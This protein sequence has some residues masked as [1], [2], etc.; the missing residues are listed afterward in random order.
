MLLL[1]TQAEPQ[2]LAFEH[3]NLGHL[4]QPR[5]FPKVVDTAARGVPWAADNDAFVRFDAEAFERMLHALASLPGCLCV[6]CPDVV[7]EGGFTDIL[8]EEWA[9]RIMRHWLPLAYAVQE[10]GLEYE[11]GG[12]PWGAIEALFIGCAGDEEKLGERVRGLVAEAKRRGKWVH[13][14]RVNSARRIAYAKEI[15][16][17]SVDGTKWV[18][19]RDTYLVEGLQ[20]VSAPPQLALANPSPLPGVEG[21]SR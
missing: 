17:D 3:R 6:T 13:M 20:L 5:H 11:W 14:G 4:V 16:C 10:E 18:R 12:V 21:G 19:W 1:A 7:G 8:F 15:G 9:P 2:M